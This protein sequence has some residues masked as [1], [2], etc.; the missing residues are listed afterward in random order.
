MKTYLRGAMPL[1]IAAL[2]LANAQD[3]T[4]QVAPPLGVVQ[5]FSVLGGS[6]VTGNGG[7]VAGDVGSYPTCGVTGFPPSL[8]TPPFILHGPVVCDGTVAR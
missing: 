7:N 6:A 2:A 3:A 4:A 5:Q 8:V 1:L